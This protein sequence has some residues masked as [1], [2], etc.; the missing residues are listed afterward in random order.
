M[1][2]AGVLSR[3]IKMLAWFQRTHH[4]PVEEKSALVGREGIE[5]R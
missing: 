4:R 5:D 3:Q 2:A 1:S